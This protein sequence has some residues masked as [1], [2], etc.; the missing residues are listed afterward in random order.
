MT[1]FQKTVNLQPNIG[2]A[3]DLATTNPVMSLPSPQGGFVAATGGVTTARFAWVSGTTVSNAGSGKPDGFLMRQQGQAL[4]TQYL[5]E[6]SNLILAGFPVDVIMRADFYALVTVA[7]ATRG[8]KA[9]ASLTDGSLQ[10]GN[11]GATISGY[12]ETDW[13]I[14]RDAVVG[15]LTVISKQ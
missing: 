3:G 11:A 14:M 10:P 5:G 8:Q 6:T 15:D 1:G 4:I 2:V 7:N 12:I 9:F 13:Y